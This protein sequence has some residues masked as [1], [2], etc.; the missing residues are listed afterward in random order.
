MSVTQQVRTGPRAEMVLLI[1]ALSAFAPLSIDMYLP[2]LPAIATD[3]GATP[4][5]VQLTLTACLVGLALGQLISGPLSDTFGRRRPL[6]VG[7]AMYT[8]ASM[9][10]AVAPSVWGLI[11]LRVLQGFGGAAGI[12]IARAVVR[13]HF[14]GSEA[15][16]FFALTMLVNGLAPILA[17]IIGGQLLLITTWQG[18]FV[19]L[20][21]IG[22]VL[23]VATWFRLRESLPPERRRSGRL[24]DV[25][26]TYRGLVTDRQFMCYVLASALAFAAMFGYISASPFIIEDVFGQSPQV[27]SLFFAVNAL[28]IVVMSQVS[29]MLVRR[30]APARILLAGLV[31]AAFGG[32][33]LILAAVAGLG[34]FGVAVGFFMVVSSY[35]L[36]APNAAALALADQPHQAGSASALLGASQFLVG[37]AAAPLVSLGGTTSVVPMAVVIGGLTW[38]ALGTFLVLRRPTRAEVAAG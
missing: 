30:V 35:G 1:G 10:C 20:G 9:L 38:A 37:A 22:A 31:I 23:F 19:V 34:L 4:A 25:A 11:A 32:V 7:L 6:L 36:I 13:D 28:G 33:M 16:R 26:R 27:F 29:G 15:A 17:P 21:A 14:A 18:V 8:V 3:L 5:E 12:V 24:A 2:G